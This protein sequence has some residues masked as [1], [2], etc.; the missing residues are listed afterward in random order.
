VTQTLKLRKKTLPV[1]GDKPRNNPPQMHPNNNAHMQ[2]KK[3]RPSGR[4]F[5]A[6]FFAE[7]TLRTSV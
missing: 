6:D 4:H 1:E 3:S 2:L 7:T 5:F